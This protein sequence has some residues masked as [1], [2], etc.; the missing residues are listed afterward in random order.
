M[1]TARLQDVFSVC[2]H[3]L[4]ALKTQE[5][6]YKVYVYSS[7]KICRSI[8]NM[9]WQDKN[10]LNNVIIISTCERQIKLKVSFHLPSPSLYAIT[11]YRSE[12]HNIYGQTTIKY[13]IRL[14]K[15][16]PVIST[17]TLNQNIVF[18]TAI[19]PNFL[20]ILHVDGWKWSVT[21]VPLK[22]T[23]FT[24]TYTKI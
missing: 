14:G 24:F 4:T 13:W 5:Q 19:I 23:C 10:L 20:V 7:C 8:V 18:N 3:M 2:M 17:S 11:T 9:I 16:K 21:H 15:C 6:N 12:C 1:L 22:H